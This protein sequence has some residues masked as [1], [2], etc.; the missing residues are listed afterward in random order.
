LPWFVGLTGWTSTDI[1]RQIANSHTVFNVLSAVVFLP[2]TKRYVRFLERVVS[3]KA[4]EH[5][6][7]LDELL[8]DRPS[9]ALEAVRAE[10]GALSRRL[11]EMLNRSIGLIAQYDE[12]ELSKFDENEKDMNEAHKEITKYLMEM[13]KHSLSEQESILGSTLVQSSNLVERMGDHFEEISRLAT[14]KHEENAV[15]SLAGLSELEQLRK[16]LESLIG[17]LPAIFAGT[18]VDYAPRIADIRTVANVLRQNH[19]DRLQAGT[20][21][22]DAGVIH[23]D[24]ISHSESIVDHIETIAALLGSPNVKST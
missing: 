12:R 18:A 5:K 19:L 7:H 17:D 13:S 11:N 21:T 10:L 16:S 8:L 22:V 4:V 3:G 23:F 2:F 24:I 9:A 14:R 15:F 20:C 1:S 6:T